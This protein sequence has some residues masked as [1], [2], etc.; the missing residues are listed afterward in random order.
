MDRDALDS[1]IFGDYDMD[2]DECDECEGHESLSGK[3]MGTT[4]FCDGSCL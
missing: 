4:V 2:D 3:D 1:H